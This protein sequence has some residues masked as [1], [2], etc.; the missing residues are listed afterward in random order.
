MR[1]SELSSSEFQKDIRPEHA[2]LT[3]EQFK[4][5]VNYLSGKYGLRIPPEKKILMEARL[6]KRINALNLK[7][8]ESY[9]HYIFQSENAQKEY[10]MFIDHITTHKTFFFRENYQFEY[11]RGLLP[12]Y[13]GARNL[14]RVNVW[15][16]GCSTGEEVYTLA[17]TLQ[18][19]RAELPALDYRITG[20]DISIPS[21]KTAAKG[22][23]SSELNFIPD[24]YKT[25][26]FTTAKEND[27]PGLQF[28][29]PEITNRINL[30]V[31]NLNGKQYNLPYMYD[32]IFC[33]NVIIYFDS[34]TRNAVLERMVAKLK[35]GGY[36]FLGHSETAL[37][38]NLPLKSIKPTIYQ[39]IQ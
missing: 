36:F 32:F 19:A 23:Y 5:L 27:R 17:I 35:P 12:E 21:L 28:H 4:R 3:D 10:P 34:K 30:G 31:L 33:R 25:K 1:M 22:F 38:T 13:M 29:F 6:S 39:K 37:G 26:Y 7:S 11:M 9:I 2:R 20:T 24:S 14:S 15:S 8:V 16:A 18:E